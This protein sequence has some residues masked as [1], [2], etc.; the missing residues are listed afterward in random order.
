[1]ESMGVVRDVVS[2]RFV[3]MHSFDRKSAVEHDGGV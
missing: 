2:R 3:C 1:M